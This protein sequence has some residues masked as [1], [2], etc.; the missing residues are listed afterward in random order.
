MK[1]DPESFNGKAILLIV[2]K[3]IIGA[4][5]AVAFVVY[6]QYKDNQA[7]KERNESQSIQLDFE[8]AKMAKEFWPIIMNS[9]NDLLVRGYT[10]RSGILSKSIEPNTGIDVAFKLYKEGLRDEDF[11][12]LAKATLPDGLNS[13]LQ[14]IT[15][16]ANEYLTIQNPDGSL[17]KPD[18]VTDLA[19]TLN[20]IERYRK[21][22]RRILY[23]SI[24]E[25]GEAKF[26]SLEQQ[27]FLS[28]NLSALFFVYKSR[29]SF[30][31]INQMSNKLKGLRLVG[32]INRIFFDSKD[33][34][35]LRFMNSQLILDY[36]KLD[37]IE[38][39]SSILQV[40]AKYRISKIHGEITVPFAKIATDTSYIL[41]KTSLVNQIEKTSHYWLQWNATEFLLTAMQLDTRFNKDGIEKTEAILIKYLSNFKDDIDK[42]NSEKQLDELTTK[43]ESGKIIRALIDVLGNT[44]TS[45]AKSILTSLDSLPDDKLRYFPFLKETIG[46][47]LN[48][49]HE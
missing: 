1:I 42:A 48:I 3:L 8:R 23:E 35:A 27:E 11:I 15:E 33:L 21:T 49:R 44:A 12:I 31:A 32:A 19:V 25:N 38:Y 45:N 24:N 36:H 2:D 17:N 39:A 46:Q 37:N 6:D 29:D 18:T 20:R 22:L 34:D 30:D 4:I 10:L 14:N 47:Q 43:Y 7:R 28:K 26:Q 41:T 40:I 13:F 16:V 5:L 9:Q